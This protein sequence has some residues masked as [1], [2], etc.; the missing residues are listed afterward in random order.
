MA[1]RRNR[2]L[3]LVNDDSVDNEPTVP[4]VNTASYAER[5]IAEKYQENHIKEG[6][7]AIE[8]IQVGEMKHAVYKRATENGVEMIKHRRDLINSAAGYPKEDQDW[9]DDWTGNM[10]DKAQAEQKKTAAI[11]GAGVDDVLRRPLDP[12]PE[13]K[14]K[15]KGFF[16]RD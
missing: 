13:P 2:S 4:N 7:K 16:S 11:T 10:T 5:R 9:I 6:F 8:G 1:Y 3:A 15:K 12:E 14:P